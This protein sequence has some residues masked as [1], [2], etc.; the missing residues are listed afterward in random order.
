MTSNTH[1]HLKHA[2]N[3][4]K[5]AHILVIGDLIVDHFIWGTVS[6]ISPEAPVPVV[7]VTHD[8]LLLGGSANVLHNIFALG[9]RATICGVI[10][11]DAMGDHL[12]GLIEALPSSTKGIVRLEDRP[13][14]IKTRIVAHGQQ[15]V[16]VDR[17]STGEVDGDGLTAIKEFIDR[18][19]DSFQAVIVSDYAKG[20]ITPPLMDHL[21][22]RLRQHPAIPLIIDPK[23]CQP[24]RFHGATIITPNHH[25]AEQLSGIRITDEASLKAAGEKLLTT[26]DSRAVLITRGEAG[27]ALFEKDKP[28][29]TIPTLAKEVF[30]VTGAGDT[31]IATLALGLASGLSFAEAASLANAAAGIVVG[32]IGTAVVTQEELLEVIA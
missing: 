9:A 13:T 7:N 26:L 5:E 16:R 8:N 30:D 14:T 18:H 23:P 20:I 17:E 3:A 11:H 24:E 32:K 29:I 12:L 15:V 6:R 2:V 31:V 22:E 10:G 4:F 1:Q 21:R 28:L 25:E 27:M 19:L